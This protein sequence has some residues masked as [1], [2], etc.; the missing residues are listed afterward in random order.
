M[1]EDLA[2][3]FG[4]QTKDV[5]SRVE[6]LEESGRLL[7]IT[8]DRGKYIHINEKEFSKLANYIKAKG[9]INRAD[10]LLEANKLV[11]MVPTAE[12]KD[13]IKQE[14]QEILNKVESS[15]KEN[16]PDE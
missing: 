8:D 15:I 6:A 11:R 2:A 13:K 5:V 3:E 9:R 12:D 14:Q 7:G 10:L 4:M 1:L 16:N